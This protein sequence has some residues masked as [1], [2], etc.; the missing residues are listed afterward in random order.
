ML[1]LVWKA[2]MMDRMRE[3]VATAGLVAEDEETRKLTGKV[4]IIWS[5]ISSNIADANEWV[6]QFLQEIVAVRSPWRSGP[7][8]G[9]PVFRFPVPK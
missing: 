5:C 2:P 1:P 7:A 8:N 3:L 6:G 9:S 4:G